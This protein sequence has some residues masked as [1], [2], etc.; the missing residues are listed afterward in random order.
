[1]WQDGSS[2]VFAS[3]VVAVSAPTPGKVQINAASC[4]VPSGH[5]DLCK[6]QGSFIKCLRENN[7][8]NILS[9]TCLKFHYSF[10]NLLIFF[11]NTKYM[12]IIDCF[13]NGQLAFP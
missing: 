4:L 10:M 9:D 3:T 5:K 1:M 8:N 6:F 13:K 7:L 12:F 11:P 2:I